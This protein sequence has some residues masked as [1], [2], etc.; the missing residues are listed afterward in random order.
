MT[1]SAAA[2]FPNVPSMQAVAILA[3]NPMA[4]LPFFVWLP[5]RSRSAPLA[6][7]HMALLQKRDPVRRGHE[8]DH[9]ARQI[10]LRGDRHQADI[11]WARLVGEARQRADIIGARNADQ[12]V[13]LLDPELEVALRQIF[14]DRAATGQLDLGL[15][16]L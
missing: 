3:R 1:R 15:H 2:A 11:E 7:L 12:H 16:L 14:G 10:L 5:K 9:I 8:P 6:W 4:S 13:G